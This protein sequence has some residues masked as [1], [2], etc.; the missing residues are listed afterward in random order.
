MAFLSSVRADYHVLHHDIKEL[1]WLKILLNEL[2]FG[3][4]KSKILFCDNTTTIEITNN[5]VQYDSTKHIELE[6]NYIRDNLNVTLLES[7]T[8]KLLIN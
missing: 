6:I 2:N 3:L 7:H 8:S 1:S 5:S 4:K